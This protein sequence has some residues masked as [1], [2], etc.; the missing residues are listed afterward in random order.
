ME[1]VDLIVEAEEAHESRV[2][3]GVVRC[4]AFEQFLFF[5]TVLDNKYFLHST[6]LLLSFKDLRMRE[7][8]GD[9]NCTVLFF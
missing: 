2:G 4:G 1:R 9:A 5:S 8:A 7:V 6:R 3:T